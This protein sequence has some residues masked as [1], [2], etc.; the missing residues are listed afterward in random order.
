MFRMFSALA[1]LAALAFYIAWPAYS[2][3]QIKQA[4]D[5][6]DQ[7]ALAAKIDFPSVR[8]SLRPTVTA[9]V[10]NEL[11][12][13]FKKAGPSGGLLT[14]EIKAKFMP[15]IVDSVLTTLVTPE[16]I[17]R[18]HEKGG[19]LKSNIESLVAARAAQPDGISELVGS[20][21]PGAGSNKD[22]LAGLNDLA[23]GF[24]IDTKKVI[25]GLMKDKGAAAMPEAPAQ[26]PAPST[27]AD[28]K[29]APHYGMANIKHLGFD[30]PFAIGFGVARDPA[31]TE[32]DVSA[33]MSFV[34]G[35]WKLT[36]LVP[37][38]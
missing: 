2:G 32:P 37:K 31:S 15:R 7:N 18:I 9:R 20:I 25:G 5:A 3:Y 35:D 6:K 22:K 28:A 36:K 4:I 13:A 17:I 12:T 10:E 26:A 24:G 21:I 30:G 38:L 8:A 29:P 14:D 23:A 19:D 16:M 34:D 33:A 11:A 27:S 1:I